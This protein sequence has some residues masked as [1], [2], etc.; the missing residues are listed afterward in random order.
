MSHSFFFRF[1]IAIIILCRTYFY[2]NIFL[3]L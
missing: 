2:W 3:N 1:Q